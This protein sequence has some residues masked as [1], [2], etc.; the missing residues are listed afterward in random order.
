MSDNGIPDYDFGSN[1]VYSEPQ[2][3]PLPVTD[4]LARKRV[5]TSFY[6][7]LFSVSPVLF[8]FQ[9]WT[10]LPAICLASLGIYR[11][12]RLSQENIKPYLLTIASFIIMITA[13]SEFFLYPPFTD[14]VGRGI[15]HD[16]PILHIAETV[17]MWGAVSLIPMAI[18]AIVCGFKAKIRSGKKIAGIVLGFINLAGLVCCIALLM[19]LQSALSH[20]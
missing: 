10:S 15:F 2:P 11:A 1:Y 12:W 17:V 18:T 5:E 9:G 13:I 16:S 20:L 4:A 3:Q 7:G 8:V 6:L 19:L 14:E